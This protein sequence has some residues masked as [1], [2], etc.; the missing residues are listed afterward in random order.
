M[1]LLVDWLGWAFLA[2]GAFFTVVGALGLVRM[3]DLY[4]RCHAAGVID[5]FGVSLIL[6]GLMFQTGFTLVT[7]KLG[8]LVILLMFSSPVATHA[9][10]RAALHRKVKPLLHETYEDEADRPEDVPSKR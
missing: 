5:P 7:A 4:T 10:A 1:S 3:P 8:F 6:V 9:L 2:A